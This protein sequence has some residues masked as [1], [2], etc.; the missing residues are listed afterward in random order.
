M[1]Y[2]TQKGRA[3]LRRVHSPPAVAEQKW[4]RI[5]PIDFDF[6][7]TAIWDNRRIRKEADLLRRI[8]HKA[9]A[10]NHWRGRISTTVDTSC[11]V[12]TSNEEETIIHRFWDYPTT[13]KVW[14][15]SCELSSRIENDESTSVTI[16]FPHALFGAEPGFVEDTVA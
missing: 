15:Y 8:C 5:L 14:R 1:D 16:D 12:C 10:V 9:L 4:D 2:S 3:M 7:W 6:Q 11:R 13:Q